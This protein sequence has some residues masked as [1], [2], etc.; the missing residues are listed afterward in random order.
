MADGGKAWG[1]F[2]V[3]VVVARVRGETREE[4]RRAR[5]KGLGREGKVMGGYKRDEVIAII[6]RLLV[7]LRF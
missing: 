6:M 2:F 3:A 1:A 7:R 5:G 4:G